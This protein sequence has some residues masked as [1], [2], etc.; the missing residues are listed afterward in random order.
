[1][2]IARVCLGSPSVCRRCGDGIIQVRN[3]RDISIQF[4]F[5]YFQPGEQCDDAH[6][7]ANGDGCNI[8]CEIEKGWTCPDLHTC[9]TVCGDG[10]LLAGVCG[11][12]SCPHAMNSR[13]FRNNVM[14]ITQTMEMAAVVLVVLRSMFHIRFFKFTSDCQWLVLYSGEWTFRLCGYLWQ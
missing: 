2:K 10:V 11:C 3:K 14:I 13:F 8:N 1:M 5:V 9:F 7:V 6:P 12:C 4:D